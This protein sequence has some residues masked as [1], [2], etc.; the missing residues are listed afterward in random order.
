MLYDKRV[1]RASPGSKIKLV[2][3]NPDDMVH[4][5]LLVNPGTADEVAQQATELGLRGE[6]MGFIPDSEDVLYHTALLRPNAS[7]IIYFEAPMTPG[8]YQYV[9]TF[10]A[11]AATMRGIL[12]VK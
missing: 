5:F 12:I 6:E 10:P 3:D 2:F 8:R 4:N 11:H 9:C 1:L 7:D